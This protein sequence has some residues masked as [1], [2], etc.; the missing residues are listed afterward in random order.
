MQAKIHEI[1]IVFVLSCAAV[2][3]VLDR[4]YIGMIELQVVC[5]DSHNF[6]HKA[7]VMLKII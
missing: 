4:F 7:G 3:E 2:A 5:Y 1:F 6:M